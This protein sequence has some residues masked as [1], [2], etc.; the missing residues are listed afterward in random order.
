MKINNKTQI[1]IMN[2]KKNKMKIN[3]KIN[4]KVMGKLINLK[5]LIQKMENS[6]I[7]IN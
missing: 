7:K 2:K 6:K 5:N 3:N 4:N 1:K